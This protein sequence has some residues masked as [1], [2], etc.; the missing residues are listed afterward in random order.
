MAA[1]VKKLNKNT[2]IKKILTAIYPEIFSAKHEEVFA[3][4][5]FYC[6]IHAKENDNLLNNEMTS[7]ILNH[8][9]QYFKRTFNAL[10][11]RNVY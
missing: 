9:L 7:V 4:F 5:Q 3:Q 1:S 11:V 10:G 2:I 6:D 8:W